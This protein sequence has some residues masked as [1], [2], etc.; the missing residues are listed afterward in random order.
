M[1]GR[2][3]RSS[4]RWEDVDAPVQIPQT[5]VVLPW[6]EHDWRAISPAEQETKLN[7]L[8]Q[9]DRQTDFDLA[10]APLMRFNLVRFGPQ[11]RIRPSSSGAMRRTTMPRCWTDARS[12][13]C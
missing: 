1:P 11:S 8:L 10:V 3:Q 9:E 2:N 6:T 13:S 4:F 12:R 5:Q 7:R